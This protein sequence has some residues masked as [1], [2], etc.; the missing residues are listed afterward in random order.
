MKDKV[1]IFG[2]PLDLGT[3]KLGVDMG[4]T[5]IRYADLNH[6]LTYNRID[7]ED[8]GDLVIKQ[9]I[10]DNSVSTSGFKEEISEVSEKLAGLTHQALKEDYVPVILGGDHSSSIGSIAGASKK[11][12]RL[13]LLWLDTHPD[14]NT[15][16]TSPSGNVHGMTVAI[17]LGHGYPELVEC[18]GFSPKILPEDICMIGVNDMDKEEGVFLKKLGVKVFTLM[19]I[20]RMGIVKVVK[21]ALKTVSD[22]TDLVHVSFDVDVLDST[23]APGT[24]ILSRG[25]LSYREISYIMK[26]LGEADVVD[27]FDIIEVN[28]LL[29]IQNKTAEL[30]VEMLMAALGGSFGDYQ[31]HYL[32]AQRLPECS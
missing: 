21:E 2:V 25:G 13:G 7:F 5:A 28:P 18:A 24:G 31:R 32:R 3:N 30:T 22:K 17:S 9:S 11:A 1:K 4:P 14:V 26:S 10:Y 23:I 15:P 29:D 27:S 16:E 8:Y 20:E 12:G 6:A 19:D